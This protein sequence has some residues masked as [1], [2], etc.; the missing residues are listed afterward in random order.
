MKPR[1]TSLFV[2]Q[3]MMLLGL[4][5]QLVC[6]NPAGSND[7]GFVRSA[8]NQELSEVRGGFVTAQGLPVKFDWIETA[9]IN[10]V[11]V[12]DKSFNLQNPPSQ[13][14]L[15]TLIQIG[16]TGTNMFAPSSINN[17]LALTVIQNTLNNKVITHNTTFNATVT[18]LDLL[19]TMNLSSSLTHQLA[20]GMH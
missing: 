9:T 10:G 20:N 15:K 18:N 4:F 17:N 13:A 12:L 3:G 7:S 8:T 2:V 19:R 5:F 11:T 14:D 16:P 1:E 6:P